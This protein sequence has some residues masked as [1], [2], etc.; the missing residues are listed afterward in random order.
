MSATAYE[1]YQM[2]TL[3][4]LTGPVANIATHC[5]E[6][7][8]VGRPQRMPHCCTPLRSTGLY[9]HRSFVIGFCLVRAL[10]QL[11]SS[12]LTLC[13]ADKSVGRPQILPHRCTS[14]RGTGLHPQRSCQWLSAWL[15]HLRSSRLM[16]QIMWTVVFVHMRTNLISEWYPSHLILTHCCRIGAHYSALAL[17]LFALQKRT[18]CFN[19]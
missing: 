6:D 16:M 18:G 9:N 1:L 5:S 4:S 13:L 3:G 8:S 11:S 12:T 7:R 17:T 10:S 19:L 15:E 2:Y 14:L